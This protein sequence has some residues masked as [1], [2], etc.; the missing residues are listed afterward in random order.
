MDQNI[1][2]QLDSLYREEK[3]QEGLEIINKKTQHIDISKPIDNDKL[4]W[5]RD[6]PDIYDGLVNG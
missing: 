5:W 1:W 6:E 2:K 4:D 3:I